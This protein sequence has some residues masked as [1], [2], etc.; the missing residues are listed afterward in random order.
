[1]DSHPM[2]S[3][4]GPRME[5]GLRK[6]DAQQLSSQ[7]RCSQT[8]T[9]ALL[10]PHP[11]PSRGGE[12]VEFGFCIPP[13]QG[14]SGCTFGGALPSLPDPPSL[15]R[16]IA[17]LSSAM[18][19]VLVVQRTEIVADVVADVVAHHQFSP[20]QGDHH[21]PRVLIRHRIVLQIVTGE[22]TILSHR[23]PNDLVP[24]EGVLFCRKGRAEA[25]LRQRRGLVGWSF[26]HPCKTTTTTKST[27]IERK[28][29]D[30]PTEVK[31]LRFAVFRLF[32]TFHN[33]S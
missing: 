7:S 22:V 2:K 20:Q 28:H 21:V 5:A 13:G 25:R 15:V 9:A 1:M 26:S 33:Y 32:L 27:K 19:R 12:P 29:T 17:P 16:D 3:K 8:G 10:L 14:P 24:P 31:A 23:P 30:S 18:R 6:E 11:L 4:I